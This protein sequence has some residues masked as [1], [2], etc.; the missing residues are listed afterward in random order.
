MRKRQIRQK[1]KKSILKLT[2]VSSK[3][4]HLWKNYRLWYVNYVHR[5]DCFFTKYFRFHCQ[6][7]YTC[8]NVG[9]DFHQDQYCVSKTKLLISGDVELNPGPLTYKKINRVVRALTLS[10]LELRLHQFGLKPLDVGAVMEI[11]SLEQC[12]IS[13]MGIQTVMAL[14]ELLGYNS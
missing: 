13:Y 2:P 11:A 3:M 10:I 14:F 12:H 4:H 6:S 7:L 9:S 1:Y 5:T 8:S